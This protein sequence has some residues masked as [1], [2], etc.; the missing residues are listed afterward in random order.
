MLGAVG[1]RWRPGNG[2]GD[3]L[4]WGRLDMWAV[5]EMGRGVFLV[6]RCLWCCFYLLKLLFADLIGPVSVWRLIGMMISLG[7]YAVLLVIWHRARWFR[8]LSVGAYILSGR[9]QG[10]IS[11]HSRSLQVNRLPRSGCNTVSSSLINW[12]LCLA[13]STVECGL[14]CIYVPQATTRPRHGM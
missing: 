8:Y 5:W 4:S 12:K 3:R 6:F 10:W 14:T 9:C 7:P 2:G 11:C 1:S 13:A